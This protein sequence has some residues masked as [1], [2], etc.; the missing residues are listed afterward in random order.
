MMLDGFLDGFSY[1]KMVLIKLFTALLLGTFIGYQREKLNKWAG[2]RTHVLV[3]LGACLIM[4]TS[5]DLANSADVTGKTADPGRLA[6]QV[7]SG[8]GFLGAGTILHSSS[9]IKGLTTAATLWFMAGIG[10]AVGAGLFF[11]SVV[12]ALLAYFVLGFMQRLEWKVKKKLPERRYIEFET[13]DLLEAMRKITGLLEEKQLTFRRMTTDVLSDGS[14][15][16]FVEIA[17]YAG[18][19]MELLRLAGSRLEGIHN[20]RIL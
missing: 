10:L 1:E 17:A 14:I 13:G 7:V 4:M 6:A 3:C 11:S 9:Q 20:F 16:V 19:E 15:R 8:I 2:L 12:A 18:F 5:M